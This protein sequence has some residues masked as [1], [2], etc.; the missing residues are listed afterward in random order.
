MTIQIEAARAA[1][2]ADEGNTLIHLLVKFEHLNG[3]TPFTASQND[4]EPHGREL[5]LRANAGEFGT[6]IPYT[7]PI[8]TSS[9]IKKELEVAVQFFMDSKAQLRGYDNIKSAA[10]RAGYPGP[11]H[12]EGVAYATWMDACWEACYVIMADVQ[13]GTSPIPTQDELI[14]SLPVLSLSVP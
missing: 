5:F 2:W 13:N 8:K 7:P 12:D 3:E 11:F 14:Q 10:L 4:P 9:Q 1:E 6:I